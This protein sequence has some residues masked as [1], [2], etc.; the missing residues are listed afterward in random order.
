MDRIDYAKNCVLARVYKKQMI[1]KSRI[2][3]MI[4][5]KDGDEV[6]KLLMETEFSKCMEDVNSV[7]D[8]KKMLN[9]E[10]RRI[11]MLGE[12]LL[13]DDEILDL[14]RYKYEFHNMR[15]IAKSLVTEKDFSDLY[16]EIGSFNPKD[17]R[18]KLAAGQTIGLPENVV[19]VISEAI[20]A[21]EEDK[22]PQM[23]DF[24]VDHYYFKALIN[25]SNK[26]DSE[27]INEY[28]KA[29]IDFYN[30]TTFL[31]AKKHKI[32]NQE[33]LKLILASGGDVDIDKLKILGDGDADRIAELVNHG[34]KGKYLLKAISQM[35]DKGKL[36]SLD[37]LASEYLNYMCDEVKFEHFGPEPIFA[38]LLLK[39]RQES[40]VRTILTAKL[41][42]ISK[43]V[44]RERLGDD[45]V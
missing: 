44:I 40:L 17:I 45:I 26:I 31:R 24:I 28:V 39:E 27:I 30:V 38:Y 8:Y 25:A 33:T 13:L 20:E 4:N 12:E 18:D 7:Q 2:E 14:L 9:N 1:E 29:K 3:R 23:I 10:I 21:Y 15:V 43:E 36:D 41:N 19:T 34:Q 11:F 42:G 16:F 6:Y 32:A 5:A 35:K 22:N 37:S